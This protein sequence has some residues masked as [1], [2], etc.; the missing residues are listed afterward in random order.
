MGSVVVIGAGAMGSG[1]AQIVAQ[2]GYSVFLNDQSQS[3][4]ASGLD[5]IT[6]GLDILAAKGQITKETK[7][8]VLGRITLLPNLKAV[9]EPG[10][11]PEP[12]S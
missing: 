2:A 7:S 3:A 1:I 9:P 6:I 10:L 12:F 8:E 5:K 4:L 11:I